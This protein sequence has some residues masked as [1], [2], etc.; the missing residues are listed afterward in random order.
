MFQYVVHRSLP[1]LEI[2]SCE[3][4]SFLRAKEQFV[5]FDLFKIAKGVNIVVYKEQEE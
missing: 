1:G 3:I 5:F 2:R 4:T